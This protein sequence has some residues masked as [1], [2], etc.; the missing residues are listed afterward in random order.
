MS[1]PRQE[2]GSRSRAGSNDG[3]S[4][5][6]DGEGGERPSCRRTLSPQRRPSQPPVQPCPGSR[7]RNAVA[8]SQTEPHWKPTGPRTG[9]ADQREELLKSWLRPTQT[10][11]TASLPSAKVLASQQPLLAVAACYLTGWLESR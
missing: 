1:H 9:A 2:N 7:M 4:T 11:T 8:A 10:Y 3:T 6:A 5:T